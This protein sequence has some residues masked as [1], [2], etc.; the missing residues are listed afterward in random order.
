MSEFGRRYRYGNALSTDLSTGF[1][2][3]SGGFDLDNWAVRGERIG[4]PNGVLGQAQRERDAM[5]NVQSETA[6]LLPDA[7]EPY[8]ARSE[9]KNQSSLKPKSNFAGVDGCRK[10]EIA[11][12]SSSASIVLSLH[13][14]VSMW[15]A[16]S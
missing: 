13:Q 16:P 10:I 6:E 2:D 15:D 12:L 9:G 5:R 14:I 8:A 11:D 7:T 3:K 4:N 1:G